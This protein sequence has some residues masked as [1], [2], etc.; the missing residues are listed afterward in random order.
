MYLLLELAGQRGDGRR[1]GGV[2]RD[3]RLRL[4]TGAATVD[5]RDTAKR[6]K[7]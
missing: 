1:G 5:G 2:V 3:R 4:R 7:V 6:K